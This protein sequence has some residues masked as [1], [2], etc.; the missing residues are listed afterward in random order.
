MRLMVTLFRSSQDFL[1]Y[2]GLAVAL[3]TLAIFWFVG[4]CLGVVGIWRREKPLAWAVSG[5][6]GNGS[7]FGWLLLT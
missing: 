3:V 1:G 2:G 4:F 6:L 7:G 5:L